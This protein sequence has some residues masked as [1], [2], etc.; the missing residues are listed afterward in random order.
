LAALY[1]QVRHEA[2]ATLVPE[3]V[4]VAHG[5]KVNR[6][7]SLLSVVQYTFNNCKINILGVLNQSPGGAGSENRP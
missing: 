7:T 4:L 1:V 5:G 3:N 6:G 2:N